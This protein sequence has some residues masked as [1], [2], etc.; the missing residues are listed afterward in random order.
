[1]GG[2]GDVLFFSGDVLCAHSIIHTKKAIFREVNF[3]IGK[4]DDSRMVLNLHE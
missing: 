3:L 4:Y 1:M 2:D